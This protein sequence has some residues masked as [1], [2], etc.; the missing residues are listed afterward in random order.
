MTLLA[1]K[2]IVISSIPG[3]IALK[4]EIV[5]ANPLSDVCMNQNSNMESAESR[6]KR[7]RLTHLSPDER[8]LRRKLKNRVA[9]QTARDRKKQRMEELEQALAVL[10]EENEKLQLENQKLKNKTGSLAD[11]NT[12]LKSKLGLNTDGVAMVKGYA[13]PE[14]A[15]LKPPLQQERAR[16]LLNL[17]THCIA[18]LMTLSLTHSLN[19]SSKS[20]V[21]LMSRLNR[22]VK[23]LQHSPLK[24]TLSPKLLK[25]LEEKWWGP[26]QRNWNPVRI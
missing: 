15:A 9:A 22:K 5:T 17:T 24:Q 26:R 12:A 10:Q 13:P 11:E 19:S 6:R 20:P 1:P 8:L 21:L 3:K 14:S 18:F 4:T 16:T 7:Q 2:G 25:H 23:R